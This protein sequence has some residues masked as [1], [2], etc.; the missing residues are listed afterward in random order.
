MGVSVGRIRKDPV[1]DIKMTVLGHN[2]I[3]GAAGGAI[4]NAELFSIKYLTIDNI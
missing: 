3:K 1:F 4:L 2:T